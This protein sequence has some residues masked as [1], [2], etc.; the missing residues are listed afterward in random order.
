MHAAAEHLR[1]G[2]L[3]HELPL[4]F[5]G[6]RGEL[7]ELAARFGQ[8]VG[9]RLGFGALAREPVFG[10]PHRALVIGDADLHRF[11]LG[12]HRSELDALAVGHDRAFAELGDELGEFGLLVGERALGFAQRAR[13]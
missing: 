9:R 10:R 1:F 13:S 11:D 12:A 3:H 6:A 7:V 5:G 2:R 8:L 4:E